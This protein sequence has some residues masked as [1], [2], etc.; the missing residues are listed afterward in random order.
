MLK[1]YE[2]HPEIWNLEKGSNILLNLEKIFELLNIKTNDRKYEYYVRF[3]KTLKNQAFP[4]DLLLDLIGFY[5]QRDEFTKA[6]SHVL[7]L[8]LSYVKNFLEKWSSKV[9][10]EESSAIQCRIALLRGLF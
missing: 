7:E 1:I 3:L 5:L 8:D 10:S 6:E 9:S 2:G 4:R